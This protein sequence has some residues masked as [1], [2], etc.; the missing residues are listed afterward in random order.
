MADTRLRADAV[1]SRERI[2]EAAREA[3]VRR[4]YDV[5]LDEIARQAGVGNATLYRHFPDRESLVRHVV[6]AVTD[7]LV[8]RG[9]KVLDEEPDAFAAVRTF[10][11]AA[12]EER[13]GALC[14]MLSGNLDPRD[15]EMRLARSRLERLTGELLFRAQRAGSLREGVES[16]DLLYALTLIT[17]PLPD[18]GCAQVSGFAERHLQ[19]L[20]DGMRAP[21]R[22]PLPGRGPTL[23]DFRCRA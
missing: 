15:P 9:R 2:V 7:R 16:G 19:L 5:A 14:S 1:R 6:L 20:L 23:E 8:A 17:R 4:G 22:S 10:A 12:A 11:F 18:T 3:L 13:V 21:A